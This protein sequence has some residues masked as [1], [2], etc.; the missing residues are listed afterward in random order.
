MRSMATFCG[1]MMHYPMLKVINRT[2]LAAILCFCFCFFI[3]V[4]VCFEITRYS[5]IH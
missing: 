2:C 4:C 1:F 5:N 3:C